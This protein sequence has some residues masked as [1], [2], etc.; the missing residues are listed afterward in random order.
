MKM[1]LHPDDEQKIREIRNIIDRGSAFLI[2][3]H[4]N[5][6]G[7]AIGSELA[8]YSMLKRLGKE[9]RILNPDRTPAI[10]NFLPY[11]GRVD[12]GNTELSMMPDV[13]IVIDC[14]SADRTGKVFNLVKRAP[15]IVNIDHHFSNPGFAHL[16]WI[17]HRFSATGEMVYFIISTAGKMPRKEATCLYTAILTDTGSFLH[18][19]SP[20]TMTVVKHLM[21]CGA[22]PERIAN[23]VYMERP[24]KSIRLLSL[25]LNNLQFERR[26]RVCWMKVS[27]EMYRLT[28]T[29]EEDTEGFIDI[30]ARVKEARVVFFVKEGDVVK[31]SLRSKGRF[32]VEKIAAKF[33]GGGHKK[34]AGCYFRN[35]T[36]EQVIQKVLEEIYRQ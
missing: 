20:Y 18:N 23:K 36:V 19:I 6:D 21:D 29:N 7:D 34:A 11:S 15:V 27:R 24:L 3:T 10:Y 30:L 14:G 8:L 25:C 33:G 35:I 9:A 31:V 16:N 32:D 17:N 2:T 12:I 28:R 26:K 22:E 1:Q 5:V 13:S 4:R